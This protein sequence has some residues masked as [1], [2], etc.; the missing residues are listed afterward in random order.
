[1]SDVKHFWNFVD[2]KRNTR[3]LPNIMHLN[4]RYAATNSSVANLFRDFFQQTYV[5]GSLVLDLQPAVDGF[6]VHNSQ[7]VTISNDEVL[8]GLRNCKN[9]FNIGTDGIPAAFLKS[10]SL[11]IATPLFLLFN[12]FF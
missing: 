3:G 8:N 1:M 2:S 9:K 5:D 7:P 10:T 6:E 11:N 4:D 12:K